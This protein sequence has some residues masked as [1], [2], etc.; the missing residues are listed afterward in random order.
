MK[1]D[2]NKK[3]YNRGHHAQNI[4]AYLRF[5]LHTLLPSLSGR[6]VGSVENK[7]GE[8]CLISRAQRAGVPVH[9]WLRSRDAA[10]ALAAAWQGSLAP[11]GC[12]TSVTWL[13]VVICHP[14]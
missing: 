2:F 9:G 1:L 5:F 7:G 14:P 6:W 3:N 13:L 10:A 12:R 11:G 8:K 4:G